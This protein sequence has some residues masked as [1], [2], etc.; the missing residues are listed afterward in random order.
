MFHTLGSF[1]L[2][3]Y[4]YTESFLI[5]GEPYVA[6]SRRLRWSGGSVATPDERR[7][8][9]TMHAPYAITAH[10]LYLP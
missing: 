9:S 1:P 2:L 6:P 5:H 3:V 10:A 7:L 8:P 4:I